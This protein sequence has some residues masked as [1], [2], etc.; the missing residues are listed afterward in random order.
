[1]YPYTKFYIKVREGN[2]KTVVSDL[3]G[4]EFSTVEAINKF[5]QIHFPEN[6]AFQPVQVEAPKLVGEILYNLCSADTDIGDFNKLWVAFTD[7]DQE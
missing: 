7:D 4:G 1:M 5:M 6:K 2:H 3:I